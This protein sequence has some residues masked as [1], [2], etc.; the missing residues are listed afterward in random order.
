MIFFCLGLLKNINSSTSEA[1]QS[2]MAFVMATNGLPAVTFVI[3]GKDG[4][5]IWVPGRLAIVN[6]EVGYFYPVTKKVTDVYG[7]NTVEPVV[8]PIAG[9]PAENEEETKPVAVI[10]A[11]STDVNE[12]ETTPIAEIPAEVTNVNEEIKPVVAEGIPAEVVEIFASDEGVGKVTVVNTY[13]RVEDNQCKECGGDSGDH[14]L[15]PDCFNKQ[16][17]YCDKCNDVTPVTNDGECMPCYCVEHGRLC[18]KCREPVQ[19]FWDPL[20]KHCYATKNCIGDG[21]N[22]YNCE[23]HPCKSCGAPTIINKYTGVHFEYCPECNKTYKST[24]ACKY[25]SKC[26]NSDC[27]YKHPEGRKKRV[28]ET[29]VGTK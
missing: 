12:E 11:E 25:G 24:I 5:V 15:C 8:V 10:P 9:L 20:C 29:K 17:K 2:T 22:N 6:G 27:D 4:E 16:F 3:K 28:E 13:T 14:K 23:N 19:R 1:N 18:K 26:Y 21:C 7:K